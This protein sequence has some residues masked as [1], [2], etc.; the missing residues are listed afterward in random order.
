M[1][2]EERKIRLSKDIRVDFTLKQVKY[3]N[4]AIFF[5]INGLGVHQ[6]SLLL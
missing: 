3:L 4:G 5:L 6:N 1:M 2:V